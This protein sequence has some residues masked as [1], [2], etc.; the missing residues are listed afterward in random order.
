MYSNIFISMG[1]ALQQHMHI[2]TSYFSWVFLN[3][4]IT[5][6]IEVDLSP[7]D[8]SQIYNLS[9]SCFRKSR[10]LNQILLS[11]ASSIAFYCTFGW[12]IGKMLIYRVSI[13]EGV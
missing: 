5:I 1:Y 2:I 7:F 8:H 13:I 12:N 10:M 9:K 11:W 3:I 4:I 6:L